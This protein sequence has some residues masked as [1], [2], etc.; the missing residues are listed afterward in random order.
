VPALRLQRTG[1]RRGSH[2]AAPLLGFV[3]ARWTARPTRLPR[4][5]LPDPKNFTP[6]APRQAGVN[7]AIEARTSPACP[8]TRADMQAQLAAIL[9]QEWKQR[10]AERRAAASGLGFTIF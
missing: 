7:A 3:T 8:L 10:S 4:T 5:T 1:P 9:R 6:P 2:A